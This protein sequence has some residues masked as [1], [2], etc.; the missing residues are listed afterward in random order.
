M[1]K[2]LG[3]YSSLALIPVSIVMFGIYFTIEHRYAAI[4]QMEWLFLGSFGVSYLLVIITYAIARKKIINREQLLTK[5]NETASMYQR[6]AVRMEQVVKTQQEIIC[7][8]LNLQNAMDIITQHTQAIT[9]ADGAVIEVLEGDDMVYRAAVVRWLP[10]LVSGL[11]HEGVCQDY[12]SNRQWL[13]NVMTV[14]V[15]TG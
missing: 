11:R 4:T 10:I 5:E 12:V 2:N 9:H 1:A 6:M 13:C 7:Q 15:M 14:I 8:R 3:Y